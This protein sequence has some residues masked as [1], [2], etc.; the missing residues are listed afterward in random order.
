MGVI[1][2]PVSQI[3]VIIY[4]DFLVILFRCRKNE[5]K[6]SSPGGGGHAIRS[7][8]RMFREDRP[9]LLGL[10]FGV[11][12]GVVLGAQ[13]ATKLLLGLPGRQQGPQIGT[14]FV[15]AF[16]L[17]MLGSGRGEQGAVPR[18][19]PAIRPSGKTILWPRDRGETHTGVHFPDLSFPEL[20][21]GVT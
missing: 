17:W 10:H 6:R 20:I 1:L 21:K 2:E 7:C 14:F 18:R 13:F 16:F 12:F 19:C 4:V 8:R 9:L 3:G 15:R 5:R 11:H